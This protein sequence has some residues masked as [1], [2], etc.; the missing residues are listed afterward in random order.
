MCYFSKVISHLK[1]T[2]TERVLRPSHEEE[3]AACRQ[4]LQT[5]CPSWTLCTCFCA[6]TKLLSHWT[7]NP[8][9]MK[10]L[11]WINVL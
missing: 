11:S 2:T 3:G 5:V 10:G 7:S 8:E 4:D 6:V 9:Q 1:T